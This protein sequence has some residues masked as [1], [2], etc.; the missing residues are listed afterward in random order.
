[1][2]AVSGAQTGAVRLWPR[3]MQRLLQ[4]KEKTFN[5]PASPLI[6]VPG[7]APERLTTA[8]HTDQTPHA[9]TLTF[10]RAC[11]NPRCLTWRERICNRRTKMHARP[12][13]LACHTASP[14]FGSLP[15]GSLHSPSRLRRLCVR[16]ARRS[17]SP[18]SHH[19]MCSPHV[20]PTQTPRHRAPSSVVPSAAPPVVHIASTASAHGSAL[21][22]VLTA[23][24]LDGGVSARRRARHGRR[25]TRR[26]VRHSRSSVA[27]AICCGSRDRCAQGVC[28]RSRSTDCHAAPRRK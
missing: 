22:R 19:G 8:T 28:E 21:V 17:P 26:R 11:T 7:P 25:V 10:I 3:F 14:Q 6:T 1:M 5:L 24:P 16:S 2:P 9:C 27:D 13:H 12:K 18:E 20:F 4:T 15:Q 23:A